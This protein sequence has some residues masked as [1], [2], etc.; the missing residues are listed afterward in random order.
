MRLLIFR[1]RNNDAIVRGYGGNQAIDGSI[2]AH[3]CDRSPS[4]VA[5]KLFS[6]QCGF[7]SE[8]LQHFLVANL[9]PLEIN[10]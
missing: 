7:I 6:R 1:L 5:A 8:S 10:L 3:N 2:G 9:L 4:S